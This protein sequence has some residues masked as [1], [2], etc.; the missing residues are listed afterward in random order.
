MMDLGVIRVRIL[1]EVHPKGWAPASFYLESAEPGIKKQ[2]DPK[3]DAEGPFWEVD[4]PITEYNMSWVEEKLFMKRGYLIQLKRKELKN[5]F[6]Q[7]KQKKWFEDDMAAFEQE[8][9]E[10]VEHVETTKENVAR[11][12]LVNELKAHSYSYWEQVKKS[13]EFKWP[14]PSRS[15]EMFDLEKSL[16]GT[17]NEDGKFSLMEEE[18]LLEFHDLERKENEERLKKGTF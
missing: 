8:Q 3:K 11:E 6:H 10:H 14:L 15:D 18:A 9:K 2:Y 4:I 1:A 13:R 5:P 17:V 12:K 16:G 7:A